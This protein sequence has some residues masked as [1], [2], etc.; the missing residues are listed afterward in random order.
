MSVEEENYMTD[1]VPVIDDLSIFLGAGRQRSP[2]ALV[3]HAEQAEGLGLRRGFISERYDIKLA[4]PL[5]GAATARTSRLHLGTGVLAGGSYHPLMA[6]AIGATLQSAF[7]ERFIMGLGRGAWSWYR[8]LGLA[9]QPGPIGK[10]LGF[11]AMSDYMDIIRR[12]WRGET[13]SYDGPAGRYDG[14]YMADPPQCA[15]PPIWYASLGGDRASKMAARAADGLMI[16]DMVTPAATAHAVRVVRGER[17]RLGLDPEFPV[18]ICVV[19]TPNFDRVAT[20]NQTSARLL[21]YVVGIEEAADALARVNGWDREVIRGFGEHPVFA[22]TAGRTADQAFHRDQLLEAAELV[23]EEW[24]RDCC[25]IGS[26]DDC[27]AKLREFRD[28]GADEVVLY[29][30][31]PEDN[32]ELI[33]Q[34]RSR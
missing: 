15:P 18:A 30:S 25:A 10:E 21:T 11:H 33:N 9:D 20:L 5:L 24:M 12:L 17:E 26:V 4:A 28:A 6:A 7:G 3:E 19:S 16:T 29:G 2:Y 31:T 34:W 22:Q 32:R 14:V 23:P 13:V 1:R 27:A 8:Q